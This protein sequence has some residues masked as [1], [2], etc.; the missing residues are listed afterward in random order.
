MTTSTEAPELIQY[1]CERCKTRFVLP[2]SSRKLG[3]A[4]T[5]SAFFMG[6]GRALKF[7]QDFGDAVGTARRELLAR[8]DDEAYQSFVLSFRFCHE[9]RQFVCNDCWSKS[10]GTCLTCATRG[11]TSPGRTR[12][13]VTAAAPD[14]PRPIIS[15]APQRRGHTRRDLGLAGVT[16]AIVLLSIE[17]GV[18]LLNA[19][20]GPSDLSPAQTQDPNHT[21][22]PG[23]TPL[24][25]WI[26]TP[27]PDTPG[28]GTPGS[29]EGPV[30]TTSD[31]PTPSLPPGVTA[32]PVTPKPPKQ[33]PPP[34]PKP[35]ELIVIASGGTMVYGGTVPTIT[36]TY[37]GFTGGDTEASL[38]TKPT[39]STVAT[40]SSP[41]GTTYTSSCTGAVDHKYVIIYSGG[42]VS[43]TQAPL[44]VKASDG[45]MTYGGTVPSITASYSGFVNGDTPA[46][47]TPQPTCLTLATSSSP[48]SGSPYSSSCTGA[49]DPNYTITAHDGTV[50]V[51]PAPVIVSP[52]STPSIIYGDAA[53]SLTPIYA[54]SI[55]PS[56]SP[57]TCTS[58]Y[59]QG[60][61][62]GSY[63][64]TCSGAVD[65]NYTFSN[66]GGSVSVGK[67]GGLDVTPDPKVI[68]AGSPVPDA[69][70]YTFTD[71]G[72]INGDTWTTPPTCTSTYDGT[73]SPGD[74]RT[75]TCSGGSNSNYLA[76]T[77]STSLLTVTAP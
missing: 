2:P 7:H 74:T 38:T 73:E 30:V 15:V 63:P 14:I 59:V 71:S 69:S 27:A 5:L 46:S 41:V 42:L 16:L 9:C 21:T 61:G 44:T 47:L 48:V 1:S 31:T 75:I 13:V 56:G 37:N 28:N 65:P 39:C 77:H 32:P 62:I 18:L 43:V 45:T 49:A 3:I 64:I 26:V 36:A 22:T 12:P 68:T 66:G 20:S 57:A 33:P 53:P 6:A 11:A 54:P 24:R 8:K 25:Q 35:G 51:N 52:D 10:R 67:R 58:T 72:F 19:T 50:T 23:S 40:S 55:V 70:F 34:T 29:T 4:G 60:D 76:P 17:G